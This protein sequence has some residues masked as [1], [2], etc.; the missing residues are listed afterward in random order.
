MKFTEEYRPGPRDT[1][2]RVA[3]TPRPIL[4]SEIVLIEFSK[5]EQ[6]TPEDVHLKLTQAG[7]PEHIQNDSLNSVYASMS[8]MMTGPR[9]WLEPRGKHRGRR[10]P[11]AIT[12]KGR[13][14]VR[15]LFAMV[16][17]KEVTNG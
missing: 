5:V 9:K 14:R 13:A 15:E 16:G 4:L 2:I 10:M 1:V 7:L 11:Y 3:V 17:N 8:G 12:E 6:A